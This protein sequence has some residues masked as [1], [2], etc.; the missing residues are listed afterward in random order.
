[1]EDQPKSNVG[2]P[3]LLGKLRDRG[4]TNSDLRDALDPLGFKW[5]ATHNFR[6]TAAT[7][8]DDGGADCPGD[9]LCG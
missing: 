2:F 5:I 9:D 8:L 1:M 3:T 6:K 7:L 4:D